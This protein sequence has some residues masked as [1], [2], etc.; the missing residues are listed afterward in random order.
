MIMVL[1]H[2]SILV[3]GQIQ[4]LVGCCGYCGSVGLISATKPPKRPLRPWR[5]WQPLLVL[6]FT[7]S[8]H[9]FDGESMSNPPLSAG[10][11]TVQCHASRKIFTCCD[12]R[13][14]LVLRLV[15]SL[16]QIDLST[17]QL[18]PPPQQWQEGIG[19]D[20]MT[21]GSEHSTVVLGIAG[22]K[23]WPASDVALLCVMT[24]KDD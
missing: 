22:E 10:R 3:S 17:L 19:A 24:Y 11:Q 5:R 15:L 14:P 20:A 23:H 8:A 6:H 13:L 9:H 16:A 21:A 7:G 1:V 12:L 4:L 18:S 2:N